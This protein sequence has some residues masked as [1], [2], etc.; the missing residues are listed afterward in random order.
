M[1]VVKLGGSLFHTPELRQ[2][3]ELLQQAGHNE[4]ILMVPGGGPF[5]DEVRYAQR[6]HRFSDTTAHHM[7]ILAMAQFGLLMADLAPQCR[8]FFYPHQHGSELEK[9]LYVW[10]PDRHVLDVAELPHSWDIS[11]DSLA[12]WLSQQLEAEELVMI[13]RTTVVSSRI[14]A[15][16]EHGVLDKGFRTLYEHQPLPTQLFHFQ[17]QALFPDKGLVLR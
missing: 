5:A 8:P 6:L 1:R 15:L 17:Q 3:L 2:W 14:T 11:S 4:T 7:A 10:L 16:I 9:G 13:K 12:L